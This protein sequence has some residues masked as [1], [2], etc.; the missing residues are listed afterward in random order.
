M[1]RQRLQR[2]VIMAMCEL[3]NGFD[4][5]KD[6]LRSYDGVPLLLSFL[7]PSQDEYLIKETLQ[8]LGRMTQA[9]GGIQAELQKFGAIDR[10]SQLLFAQM[11][12]AQIA[13][14][15]ALAL[16]NLITEVPA[17]LAVVRKHPKFDMIRFEMLLSKIGNTI[18]E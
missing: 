11:H 12:D 17:L 10:Y 15:A 3:A 2:V 18:F 5:Y 7:S 9:N 16:V 1:P 8:L 13:E 4:P 14:L 6:L